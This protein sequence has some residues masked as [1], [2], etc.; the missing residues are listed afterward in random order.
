MNVGIVKMPRSFISGNTVQNHI[1]FAV[2]TKLGAEEII[3]KKN[4]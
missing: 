1:F 3:F 2:E 4:V